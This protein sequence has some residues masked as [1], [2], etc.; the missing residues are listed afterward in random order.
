M[1]I[2]HVFA[3]IQHHVNLQTLIER[4]KLFLS[5]SDLGICAS[6][7]QRLFEVQANDLAQGKFPLFKIKGFFFGKWCDM[8]DRKSTRLNSS[9]RL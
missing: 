4:C 9:H 7:T 2:N 5:E 6:L 3:S 1:L 8:S